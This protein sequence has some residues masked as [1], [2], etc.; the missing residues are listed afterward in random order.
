M[1]FQQV[2]EDKLKAEADAF[3]RMQTGTFYLKTVQKV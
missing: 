3:W 1:N 2:F